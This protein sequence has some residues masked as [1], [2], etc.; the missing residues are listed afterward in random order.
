MA[1]ELPILPFASAAALEAW[2]DAEHERAPGLWLQI[3]KKGSGVPSVTYEEA[4]E[5]A[6]CFGWID[7]QMR[8]MDERFYLQRFTPRRP[9]SVWSQLNVGKA[10]ALIAAGR[11]RPAG[12]AQIEAA[13]A[14]GRWEAAYA[15]QRTATVPD[16]LQ[17]A[18]DANPA[19]AAA[20]AALDGANRYAI[21]HRIQLPA[22]RPG[23]RAQ[24]IE[25]YLAMLARG[26][27]LHP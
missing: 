25:R 26:E 7:G 22:K 17:A 5:V 16:D 21:L 24:R 18:L 11:M 14:D 9:R 13:K 19:A 23:T 12:L 3:A 1:D 4:I 2:L 15:G 8:G 6:L 10:Q 27:R 20:F